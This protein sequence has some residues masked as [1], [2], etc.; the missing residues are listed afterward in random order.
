MPPVETEADAS[1]APVVAVDGPSGSGKGTIAQALARR[2]D[3]HYLDSGALYRALGLLA[4]RAGVALSDVAALAEL[5]RALT[6]SFR[7]GAVFLGDERIDRE[8]RSEQAGERASRI[9]PLPEVRAELLVWQRACARPPG[10]VADGR[11]MGTVVFPRAKC[12]IFL[13]ASAQARAKR[14]FKQLKEKGFDVN[15]TRLFKEIAERD[16]RDSRR[17]V[18]PL[19]RAEGATALDTTEL[20]IDEA[21][22]AALELVH[23]AYPV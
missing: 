12:K 22:E 6:L 13:T 15:I 18:S 5:A 4:Q 8:I 17:S 14:R 2:L 16:E 7:D 11:D 19:R 20:S 1:D 23:R 3:W 9:A 21:I 10:L